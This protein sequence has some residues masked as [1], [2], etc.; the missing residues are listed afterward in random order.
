MAQRLATAYVQTRLQLTNVD[1]IRLMNMLTEHQLIWHVNYHENGDIDFIVEDD[2]QKEIKLSFHQN[3]G[4]FEFQGSCCLSSPSLVAVMRRAVSEFKG[5][6][7]V[8][9]VYL[10][11]DI[12]YVYNQ[13]KVVKI[14]ERRDCAEHI[15]YEQPIVHLNQ[16][17]IF[18]RNTVEEEIQFIYQQIDQFLAYRNT[19]H[20]DDRHQWI[21]GQLK[22]FTH[23]LFVLEA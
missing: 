8:H 21:D 18:L 6:A 12:V 19:L 9:R 14:I 22:S 20:H 15:I 7:T 4:I 11:F 5:N 17:L 16:E 2:I 3:L 10:Q 13:G 23:R 1:M